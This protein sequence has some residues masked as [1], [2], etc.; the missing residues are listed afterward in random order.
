MVLGPIMATVNDWFLWCVWSSVTWSWSPSLMLCHSNCNIYY[1]TLF[2]IQDC[3]I[4]P[5]SSLSRSSRTA[6][7]PLCQSRTSG[8][9]S[10]QRVKL[11][12]TCVSFAG[13][14]TWNLLPDQLRTSAS[15]GLRTSARWRHF[16]LSRLRIQRIRDDEPQSR[17]TVNTTIY[18][19][20]YAQSK[21]VSYIVTMRWWRLMA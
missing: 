1:R 13:P 16:Y 4:P 7:T 20:G 21:C 17:S 6:P 15:L 8:L 19:K 10:F 11:R 2:S 14:H 3:L 5:P 12:P 18:P 9:S